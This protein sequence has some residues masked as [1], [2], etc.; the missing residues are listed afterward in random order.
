MT[1]MFQGRSTRLF[2]VF[3]VRQLKPW[4]RALRITGIAL[5]LSVMLCLLPILTLFILAW[6]GLVRLASTS[7]A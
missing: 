1:S 2:R 6:Y 7:D 4:R 3:Y 5:S